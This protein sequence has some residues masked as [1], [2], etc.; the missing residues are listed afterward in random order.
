MNVNAHQDKFKFNKHVKINVLSTDQIMKSLIIL[1][2]IVNMHVVHSNIG[3]YNNKHVQIITTKHIQLHK[4]IM[5]TKKKN[6]NNIKK[7]L[8]IM[9]IFL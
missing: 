6:Y 5:E 4:I 2:E 7:L 8:I 1:R 9:V 3:I